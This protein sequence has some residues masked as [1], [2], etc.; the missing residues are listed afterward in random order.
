MQMSF[1]QG[2]GTSIALSAITLTI[3]AMP[4]QAQIAKP[5]PTA[6]PEPTEAK[7]ARAVEA[8]AARADRLADR[9]DAL[10]TY[11]DASRRE[12]VVVTSRR[13]RLTDREVGKRIGARS[14][15]DKHAITKDTVEAIQRKI[16]RK[17]FHPAAGNYNYASYLDLRTGNVVLQTNAPTAVTGALAR[18]YPKTIER[19]AGVVTDAYSRRA[20]TPAFWGGSSITNSGRLCSAGFIVQKGGVRFMLTA[21]HC[22]AVGANVLTTDGGLSVGS[23]TQR[24]PIPQSPVGWDMELVGGSSYGTFIYS[25][26]TNSSTARQVV[27][28]SDPVVGFTGYCHSG[29]TTGEHC[30][31][32]VDSVNAQVCTQTGCKSPVIAWSLG[33]MI[34]GGDSGSPFYLPSGTG[35]SIRGMNIATF[36]DGTAYAE[37]WS[38][39]SQHLGVAIVT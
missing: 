7:R 3:G 29:Q 30:G 23:V 34:Q 39:I 32:R 13:S 15:V 26:G 6:V 27:G 20:D 36:G 21:G 31:H 16:A 14:R 12:H 5:E 18:Q 1:R 11:Y 10:G 8:G 25:G 28:A 4:A 9:T 35:A 17:N 24:G 22:F 2:V 38:R 33:T 19:E 37:K